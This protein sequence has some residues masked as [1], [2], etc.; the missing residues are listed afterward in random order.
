[1]ERGEGVASAQQLEAIGAALEAASIDPAAAERLR[2]GTF[3]RPPT[4]PAG[5]GD[6]FGLTSVPQTGGDEDEEPPER[7]SAAAARAELAKLRRDRDAAARRAAKAREAA[8]AL[9][10]ELAGMRT[11][12][13]KVEAKHA[14]AEARAKAAETEE[15]RAERAFAR[16]SD[17]LDMS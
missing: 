11:R 1:M 16:A 17:S 2:A 6:V 12:M 5:F 10:R 7:R 13:E 3:E 14:E 4:E 15:K 9:A 8:D